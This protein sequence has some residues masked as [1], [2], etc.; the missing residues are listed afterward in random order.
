M[1]MLNFQESL[2]IS[3]YL[4]L[5]DQLIPK[6]HFL[7]QMNELVDFT[8][9]HEE[10]ASKYCLDNG[11]MAIDPIQLFK[12]LLLKS[13]YNLSDRDLVERSKFD[14]S[15]KYFLGLA[16]EAD[17][18]DPTT[19]TKFRTVRLKDGDLLDMLISK[20]VEIAL[21]NN[22]IQGTDLIID[23]T[24]TRSKYSA[25]KPQEV[26][27]ERAK[28]LRKTIYQLDDSMKEIFPK[29]ND[30]DNLDK[31]LAYCQSL[32]ESI[33]SNE[34]LSVYPKVSEKLN[35]LK[36]TI[37]D[38]LN[39][40]NSLGKDDA[41]IGHKSADHAFLGY[42]THIAMSDE[43]IITAAIVT[44]GEKADGQYLEKLYTKSIVNGMKIESVIGDAAYS[45]K[46]NIQ[47]SRTNK[48]HLVA[49][50]NTAVSN[51]NRMNQKKFDYNKDAGMYV[52][53][54]GHQAIRKAKQGAKG[55]KKNQVMA[56]YFDIEKCK[57]CKISEGCYKNGAKSKTYSVRILSDLHSLQYNFQNGEY[58]KQKSKQRYKIEAKNSELKRRHGYDIASSS[59]L[60]G[61]DIQ[62]A[63][64]V[65]VVNLKR[66][67]TLIN[68][69]F[70]KKGG[71]LDLSLSEFSNIPPFYFILV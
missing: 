65:F 57:H 4:S 48:F 24:H 11:R 2:I 32:I 58:F 43:R 29:R 70:L 39:H 64:T 62:A 60:L 47:F 19:L 44:T 14:L 13:I 28:Q 20:T 6:D 68:E 15:F 52:C 16:P 30:E 51:G 5:Y 66:I 49:K 45:G 53:P 46:D 50:L 25:R 9:V 42:K 17:V 21:E 59:G 18:I 1:G 10:L 35:L 71:I 55:K 37:D 23:A 3:P 69:K 40:L 26:L 56:Y 41:T 12:Y 22:V 38:D 31:E 63:T 54:A 27:H 8:F 67:M 7:R 36:E 33:E 34:K 61:I